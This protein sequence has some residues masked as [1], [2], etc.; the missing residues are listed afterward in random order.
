[1][2]T[3]YYSET[4]INFETKRHRIPEYSTL[5]SY[6]GDNLKYCREK[7]LWLKFVCQEETMLFTSPCWKVPRGAP[8][9]DRATF[10][11]TPGGPSAPLVNGNTSQNQ[12]SI[13]IKI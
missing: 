8:V 4:S 9:F 3:V 5:R 11:A 6:H 13:N 10:R 12:R 7:I 2:E 1:M